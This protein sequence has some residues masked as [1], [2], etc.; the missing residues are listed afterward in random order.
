MI[1]WEQSMQQTFEYYVVD[2][3]TWKDKEKLDTVIS[4]TIQRDSTSNT[5]GSATIDVINTIGEEY[6]RVYLIAIQNEV[7]YKIPLGTYIVQ[8]PSTV[9]NGRYTKATMDAYTPLLELKEKYPELG[10]TI[11]KDSNIMSKAYLIAQE[12]MR[13]PVVKTESPTNLFYDFVANVDDNYLTFIKDL[14]ANDKFG[15]DI[16]EMGRVLFTPDQKLSTLQPVWTY[17]D[18]NSSILYDDVTTEHDMYGVPNVVEVIYSNGNQV[19]RSRVVNNDSN[20]PLSVINRGREIIHR[21]TSPNI[22]GNPSQKE[23]DRYATDLLR[24]LSEIEYTVTYTHGYCPVRVGDCVRL[25]YIKAGLTDVKAKVINQQIK[26][27]P[28]CPVTEKAV[29]TAKLWR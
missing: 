7:K 25:N 5:L 11:M 15:F 26:C 8:T 21:D 6:I 23:I 9:F 13:A 2:P 16:D 17:T 1:N 3:N 28:G 24:S 14:I 29:F 19:F 4:S 22:I 10:Y 20:S 18:D 27:V 12:N